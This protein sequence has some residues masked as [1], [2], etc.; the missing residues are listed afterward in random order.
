MTGR[1]RNPP[2]VCTDCRRAMDL[3]NIP[4]VCLEARP[5]DRLAVRPLQQRP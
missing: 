2:F 1:G 5:R 4:A 3:F